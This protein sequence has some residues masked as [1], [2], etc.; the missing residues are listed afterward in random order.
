M[1]S[2]NVTIG[3]SSLFCGDCIEL[4]R[5]IPPKSVDAVVVDPPYFQGVNHNGIRSE[6]GDL[7]ISKPFF[8]QF[9]AGLSLVCKEERAVYVFCDWRSNGFFMETM[10]D[11]FEVRNSLVWLK[12][13]GTGFYYQNSYETILFHCNSGRRMPLSNVL[14]G[15]RSFNGGAK[16]TNGKKVHPTQKPVELIERLITDSTMPDMTVLDPMMGSGTT[17]IACIK[18]GQKFIGIEIQRKYFDLA[19]KRIEH[20]YT[21]T[22][23]EDSVLQPPIF[24]DR[25]ENHE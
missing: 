25:K 22:K 7:N 21:E 23:P 17:G 18:T 11:Y 16:V 5:A 19:C 10:S 3:N 14:T 6:R 9:F 2:D 1:S 12:H 4:L 8:S 13:P 24:F 20:A 15:I